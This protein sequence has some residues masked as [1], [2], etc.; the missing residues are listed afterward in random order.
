MGKRKLIT[1][2]LLVILVCSLWGCA[3]IKVGGNAQLASTSQGGTEIASNRYWYVLWG[4]VPLGDNATDPY[5]PSSANK[6][7][8]ETTTTFV[9]GLISMFTGIVSI[10][11]RTAVIYEVK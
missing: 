6:V 9:D 10:V 5:I 7:R 4:L 2:I 11:C 1:S 3:T 8:V